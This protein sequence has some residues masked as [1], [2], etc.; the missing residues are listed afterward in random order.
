MPDKPST[1]RATDV[2]A[3][4]TVLFNNIYFIYVYVCVFMSV[5]IVCV[6]VPQRPGEGVGSPEPE[7]RAVVSCLTC[8]LR[9]KS[10]LLE[11]QKV[12][13]TAEPGIGVGA[14]RRGGHCCSE[15]G[16]KQVSLACDSG[17]F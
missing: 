13:L 3:P 10:G 14:G 12:L 5:C 16:G 6:Q 9:T 1:A 7:F 15:R 17:T 8:V 4:N 11:E 2:P